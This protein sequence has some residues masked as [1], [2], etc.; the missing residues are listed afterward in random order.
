MERALQLAPSVVVRS[1]ACRT[2]VVAVLIALFPSGGPRSVSRE[3]PLPDEP[4]IVACAFSGVAIAGTV[5]AAVA[6]ASPPGTG[7]S[8][9][10]GVALAGASVTL[11]IAVTAL[12]A[13][14]L[15]ESTRVAGGALAVGLAAEWRGEKTHPLFPG[16]SNLAAL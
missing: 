15:T 8:P 7:W 1:V 13:L 12:R 5:T 4:T 9:V 16:R 10:G 14:D 11:T 6:W 3:A 2:A